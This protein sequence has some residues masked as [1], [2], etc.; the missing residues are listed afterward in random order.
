[1]WFL[2][3]T[4][5]AWQELA[6]ATALLTVPRRPNVSALH[7]DASALALTNAVIEHSFVSV[8]DDDGVFV[9]IVRRRPV[10]EYCARA[11]SFARG[12]LAVRPDADR[13]E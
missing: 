1:M 10:I 6:R 7:V 9:G 4:G 11:A 13:A 3:R 2:L 12:Q 5:G 8:V